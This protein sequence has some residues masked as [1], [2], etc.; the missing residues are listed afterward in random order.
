MSHVNSD[1]KIYTYVGVVLYAARK[2]YN[3]Q[4]HFACTLLK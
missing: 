4:N 1:H 2:G 3:T